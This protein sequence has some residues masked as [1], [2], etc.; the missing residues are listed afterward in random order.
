MW[1]IVEKTSTAL[2]KSPAQCALGYA[3]WGMS[4]SW[5]DG[6]T[7]TFIKKGEAYSWL[8]NGRDTHKRQLRLDAIA[9]NMDSFYQDFSKNVTVNFRLKEMKDRN[10]VQYR[11]Y[12][13]RK[14]S[15]WMTIPTPIKKEDWDS[16]KSR[17]KPTSFICKQLRREMDEVETSLMETPS[18]INSKTGRYPFD[19][20]EVLEFWK[21][22][23]S[24]E[25][26]ATLEDCY[27][28]FLEDTPNLT[29]T[30]IGSY[31]TTLKAIRLFSE[32]TGRPNTIDR[33]DQDWLKRFTDF[34][35]N[36]RVVK[37]KG[38][39][40]FTESDDMEGSRVKAKI[41]NSSASKYLSNI[42][43]LCNKMEVSASFNIKSI[44]LKHDKGKRL[45]WFLTKSEVDFL[46]RMDFDGEDEIARDLYVYCCSTGNRFSELSSIKWSGGD[47]V[48]E[49]IKKT[50]QSNKKLIDDRAYEILQKWKDR[51]PSDTENGLDTVSLPRINQT[52]LK[53]AI[54]RIFTK[55]AEMQ[56]QAA[57]GI[58][59]QGKPPVGLMKEVSV[60]HYR[61][62][63]LAK[64]S[65][66]KK[67]CEAFTFHTSRHTFMKGMVDRGIDIDLIA[68]YV[69]V[70][71]N[72]IRKN[73][74]AHD[75]MKAGQVITG[76]SI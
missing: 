27:E 22:E 31:N 36:I 5:P 57:Y 15:H 47:I 40:Y 12:Y 62:V 42:A 33:L 71:P 70:D 61:G 59:W 20:S 69:G 16:K 65:G 49:H 23:K 2:G 54:R 1:N 9:F 14:Q 26:I 76:K 6:D 38:K 13:N 63:S 44:N 21:D 7:V 46:W 24:G 8:F 55:M 43:T 10:C 67:K 34:L 25:G 30:T 56:M 32:Y 52:A 17:P 41:I 75:R 19:L 18:M 37:N 28:R 50:K 51:Q 68:S 39:I 11:V 4:L 74:A 73:Y 72:T 35:L 66:Y 3:S 60:T 58:E 45:D 64:E 53:K 29:K 48:L